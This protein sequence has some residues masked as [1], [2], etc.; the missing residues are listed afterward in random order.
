M[1]VTYFLSTSHKIPLP[2]TIKTDAEEIFRAAVTLL[3]LRWKRYYIK[4]GYI[5]SRSIG[6]SILYFRNPEK[7]S[8]TRS[9]AAWK[10]RGSA[11]LLFYLWE[12]EKHGDNMSSNGITLYHVLRKWVKCFKFS[13]GGTHMHIVSSEAY[14]D[15]GKEVWTEKNQSSFTSLGHKR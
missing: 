6:H 4:N 5:L 13:R 2:I 7:W 14:F 3:L 15:E 11:I 1:F 12:I 10:V 8:G 9:T